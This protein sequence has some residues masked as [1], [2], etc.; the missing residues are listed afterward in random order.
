MLGQAKGYVS[1]DKEL[2]YTT[3][4]PDNVSTR[5]MCGREYDIVKDYRDA[6]TGKINLP[7]MDTAVDGSDYLVLGHGKESG[8]FLWFVDVR[9]TL[10]YIPAVLVADMRWKAELERLRQQICP[11]LRS[12][13]LAAGFEAIKQA[14]GWI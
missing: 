13:E 6:L 10:L 8:A 12:E 3:K 14:S 4:W 2:K 7:V 5:L 1:T 9:D 11:E